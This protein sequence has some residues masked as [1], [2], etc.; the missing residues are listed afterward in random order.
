MHR[1]GRTARAE[2][3]GR[4]IA[5]VSP[6][7][8]P[9]FRALMAA[10]ERPPPPELP[11]VRY[12]M[13]VSRISRLAVCCALTLTVW[14]ELHLRPPAVEGSITSIGSSTIP[15][16]SHHRTDVKYAWGAARN[17]AM[18]WTARAKEPHGTGPLQEEGVMAEC[19]RRVRLAVRADQ[20]SRRSNRDAAERAWRR[21]QAQELGIQLSDDDGA[22]E[23]VE[24][25][26]DDGPKRAPAAA[27]CAGCDEQPVRDKQRRLRAAPVSPRCRRG[28]APVAQYGG[29]EP[30]RLF[31]WDPPAWEF[32]SQHA[33]V[34]V[35]FTSVLSRRCVKGYVQWT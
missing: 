18:T 10:L 22:S 2:A 31:Q 8:A 25:P 23:D 16:S 30:T 12:P 5:L 33:I 29:R 32:L 17:K 4:S 24:L 35:W 21:R 28:A 27:G 20:L 13:V 3:A 19:R 6:A 7:E 34:I 1:A 15:P 14:K 9:R 26:Q 11:L